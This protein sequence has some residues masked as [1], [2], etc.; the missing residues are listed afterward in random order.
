[1]K[2]RTEKRADAAVK[3]AAGRAEA[4]EKVAQAAKGLTDQAQLKAIGEAVVLP[5][6]QATSNRLWFIIIPGIILL[7]AVLAVFVFVLEV[8]GNN[9]TN[10]A[11]IT[12]ALTFVLGAFVG[13]FAKSPV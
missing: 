7:A 9:K 10:P 4:I 1:M 12:P 5:P 11:T 6:D 2:S 13:L 8:D 3:F